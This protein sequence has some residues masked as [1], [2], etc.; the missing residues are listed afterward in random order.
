VA[1]ERGALQEANDGGADGVTNTKLVHV[2]PRNARRLI[3]QG[4][5]LFHR[6]EVAHEGVRDTEAVKNAGCPPYKLTRLLQE[7]GT[8]SLILV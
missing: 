2:L 8:W 7:T 4:R 3:A 6:H 1:R 5:P